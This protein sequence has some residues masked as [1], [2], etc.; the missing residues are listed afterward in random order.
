MEIRIP[1]AGTIIGL[2]L[3]VIGEWHSTSWRLAQVVPVAVTSTYCKYGSNFFLQHF[4]ESGVQKFR[5]WRARHGRLSEWN[6]CQNFILCLNMSVRHVCSKECPSNNAKCMPVRSDYTASG[7]H[8]C[9]KSQREV[10][11]SSNGD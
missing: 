7:R 3:F 5:C 9:T 10:Q 6:S 1:I 2:E 8:W 4:A 11:A